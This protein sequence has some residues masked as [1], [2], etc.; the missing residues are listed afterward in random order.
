[1]V[2]GRILDFLKWGAELMKLISEG[3]NADYA[4]ADVKEAQQ[5]EVDLFIE[6]L[7]HEAMVINLNAPKF[8]SAYDLY[9]RQLKEGGAP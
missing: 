1:M 3:I 6:G 4:D 7:K 8:E 5:W 9:Q 2:V